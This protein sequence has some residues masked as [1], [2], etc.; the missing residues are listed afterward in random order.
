MFVSDFFFY[1]N[2]VANFLMYITRFMHSFLQ[3]NTI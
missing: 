2:H 1:F 3:S